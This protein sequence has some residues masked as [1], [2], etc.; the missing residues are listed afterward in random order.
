M[1]VGSLSP[2]NPPAW[3][4]SR[5]PP[6]QLGLHEVEAVVVVR[7]EPDVHVVHVVAVVGEV[8]REVPPDPVAVDVHDLEA[9]GAAQLVQ[10]RQRLAPRV[11][12]GPRAEADD[13]VP[14]I[15]HVADRL[16]LAR[17]RHVDPGPEPPL[18]G[19]AG[20]A[21]HAA[22]RARLLQ[23]RQGKDGRLARV[24]ELA[25]DARL[26]A[27][28]VG[29]PLLVL[30]PDVAAADEVRAGIVVEQRG[31]AAPARVHDRREASLGRA[32]EAPGVRRVEPVD[33]ERHPPRAG[34]R[35]QLV[36]RAADLH[37][38]PEHQPAH[39]AARANPLDRLPDVRVHA[40]RLVEDDE[41]APV[42]ALEA[43]A[44]VRRE[45]DRVVIGVVVVAQLGGV[46]VGELDAPTVRRL[47][48]LA[49]EH[50]LDLR[51]G[52]RRGEHDPVRVDREP[53]QH[54]LGGR[55]RLAARVARLHRRARVVAHAAQN[56]RARGPHVVTQEVT[57]ERHGVAEQLRDPHLLVAREGGR[58]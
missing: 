38:V 42:V 18:R 17:P 39:V 15:Q 28:V 9:V 10:V 19:R 23:P 41:H 53:P 58:H 57:R 14:V 31:V 47:P 8:P 1:V 44:L 5:P 25:P 7:R 2:A 40:R 43:H 26:P 50:A 30:L 33:R 49:P 6:V 56:V 24:G 46:D 48:H 22:T 54:H 51:P 55:E 27:R 37:R 35:E 4:S 29:A 16:V 21:H 12:L 32:A 36:E 3:S 34:G 45:A 13:L 52:G 11:P 20:G